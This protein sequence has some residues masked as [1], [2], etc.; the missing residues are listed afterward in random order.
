MMKKTKVLIPILL[1]SLVA[2]GAVLALGIG[3]SAAFTAQPGIN[4]LRIP[5]LI[6]S[7]ENDDIQLVLQNGSHSFYDGVLSDTSGFNGDY[8]GPTIRLYRD[9]VAN[10]SF[11][12]RLEE[13]TTVHGHGLHVNGELDGGPQSRIMPGD[14][15]SIS[16]P[17]AQEAGTSWYHPHLMGKTAEQV[18]AGLAGVYIIED[19]NSLALDLPR[20]Y[21]IND[22]PLVVQD[23]SFT[24]GRMN[25]Y[26]IDREQLFNG[27]REDT[28]VVNGTVDA[29]QEVP[30]G[31]VRLR[32][33]NGSNSRFYRFSFASGRPFYKIATEGGFLNEPVLME[34]IEMAPGERNEIM[35]DLSDAATASLIADFLPVDPEDRGRQR[36][37]RAQ[38]L[39][40][41]VSAELEASGSLPEVLNDIA[42]FSRSDAVK[43]R[44]FIMEMDGING[45]RNS[46]DNSLPANYKES[47]SINGRPM[48][49]MMVNERINLGDVEI[50]R[51][52]AERMPH[53][54]HIHGVSFQIL[55]IA[56]RPPAEADRG[57][58]DTVVVPPKTVVEVIL[59]F[60]HAASDEY[61]FMYHCHMLEHEEGGMMGQFT[62]SE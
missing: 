48:N 9:R 42:F 43:T 16:I 29:Y 28:L 6:D 47:F 10:I 14:T 44:D 8:L 46:R 26:A 38:V 22:I 49:M 12:N 15:W 27:L 53:P 34:S 25:D 23:R 55:S 50:W 61:P 30:A 33:L 3:E 19:E 57:W 40:L 7:M 4:P 62:V 59:R 36:I 37:P 31:W 58:K 2:V 24:D 11:T 13:P 56:G 52:Q 17:V 39:E 21:G 45:D 32:L 41:R 35:I 51:I 1:L 60:D 54:F 20:D 5:E 18:H